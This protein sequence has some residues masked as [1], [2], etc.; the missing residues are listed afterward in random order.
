MH[1][2]APLVGGL[3]GGHRAQRDPEDHRECAGELADRRGVTERQVFRGHARAHKKL[4]QAVVG[5]SQRELIEAKGVPVLPLPEYDLGRPE[6]LK[7]ALVSGIAR[8]LYTEGDVVVVLQ[9]AEETGQ[10]ALQVLETGVLDNVAAIFGGHV[11][12]RFEVGQVVADQGPLAA[13]ADTFE[14]EIVGAGAHAARPHES[15]DPIVAAAAVVT[16][17]QTIVARRLNPATPGVVTVGTIRAGTATNVIPERATLSGTVRAVEPVSRELM[18]GE[19]A[20]IARDVAAAY[21]AEARGALDRG[22]PPFLWAFSTWPGKTLRTTWSEYPG[23]FFASVRGSPEVPS[24][25]RTRLLSILQRKVSSWV[26]RYSHSARVS[27]RPRSLLAKL[28]RTEHAARRYVDR[29]SEDRRG[30]L[31]WKGVL[32]LSH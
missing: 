30:S 31:C 5:P 2:G 1:R 6:K 19:V 7:I 11:D 17:L 4:A 26:R 28:P 13:S 29:A 23:A 14:I 32:L 3:S 22:T 15:R 25:P 8:G 27:H 9:P 16:A 24:F 12:R 18:L 21:G 20:R 10:G